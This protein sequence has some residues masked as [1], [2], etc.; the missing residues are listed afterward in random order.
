MTAISRLRRDKPHSR[1]E[2]EGILEP[3]RAEGFEFDVLGFPL[4]EHE[5]RETL[6]R[7]VGRFVP[8]AAAVLLIILGLTFRSTG[9]MTLVLLNQLAV[10]A[11]LP[12]MIRLL[13]YELHV[14]SIM[15]FPVAGRDSP[16]VA[17][18]PVQRVAD[19]PGWAWART[20]PWTRRCRKCSSPRLSPR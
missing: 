19:R 14:F 9:I 3:F 15:L 16:R 7:D 13:G 5:L 17:R 1:L 10:M 4:I 11:L 8:A 12:G 20:K 6:R 2:I 18:A